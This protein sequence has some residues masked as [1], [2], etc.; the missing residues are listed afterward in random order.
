MKTSFALLTTLS[1]AAVA[2]SSTLPRARSAH[3]CPASDRILVDSQTVTIGDQEIQV[4]TKA[5]SADAL[6]S[7]PTS[8]AVD[9]RQFNSCASGETLTYTCVTNQGVGPA[10]ADCNALAT[11]IT[12]QFGTNFQ[13]LFTVS[14]QFV[15]EFSLGTCLYAWINE[16]PAGGATLSYCYTGVAEELGFNIDN[17]CIVNGDTG[18]FVVPSNPNL[19][20]ASID[21]VFEVLHT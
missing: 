18:G 9:K 1:L 19:V 20:P 16:N 3:G 11:A 7:A 17:S 14:P 6:A 15:Q 12:N 8:R 5:C 13:Q 10:I 2:V 21:W 4:S